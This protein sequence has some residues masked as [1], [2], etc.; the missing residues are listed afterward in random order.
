MNHEE[1]FQG[2]GA[3]GRCLLAPKW[4]IPRE[5]SPFCL[6]MSLRVTS[7][8]SQLSGRWCQ[9]MGKNKAKQVPAADGILTDMV[10]L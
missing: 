4:E 2:E 10:T 7:E 3:S 1:G 6:W 9:H 8:L 5:V